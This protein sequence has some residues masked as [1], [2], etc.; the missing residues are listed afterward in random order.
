MA[1]VSYSCGGPTVPR[2]G[3]G[4]AWP[5][6]LF[7][8]QLPVVPA[9]T[10]GLS[11]SVDG[12]FEQEGNVRFS[13]LC[14]VCFVV[15]V[16]FGALSLLILLAK[17][18]KKKLWSVKWRAVFQ[19]FLYAFQE[20]VYL[21]ENVVLQHVF[22]HVG[23]LSGCL[24]AFTQCPPPP[25]L[26]VG[27][28]QALHFLLTENIGGGHWNCDSCQVPGVISS[29]WSP[30]C[31]GG[32]TVQLCWWLFALCFPCVVFCAGSWPLFLPD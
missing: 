4:G 21:A 15:W 20:S 32:V 28:W 19:G 30:P 26:Y 13:S 18:K 9:S 1:R 22:T 7:E 11:L 5:Q 12:R 25:Q 29:T 2:A 16:F 3:C 31:C 10:S 6:V 17:K 24:T 27:S 14:D 8:Q 23:G